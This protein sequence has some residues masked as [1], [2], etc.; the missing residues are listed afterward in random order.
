LHRHT[1]PR[2]IDAVA[3]EMGTV[4]L[5]DDGR[6]ATLHGELDLASYEM[7]SATLGPMFEATGDV[8]LDLSDVTFIDSSAIRLFVRLQ[9]S[10]NDTGVVRLRGAAPHV[11]RVLDVA[12]VRDLGLQIEGDEGG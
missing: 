1:A 12:G 3:D 6:G 4:E 5:E 8:V 10:R 11:A 7:I 2:S 9:E